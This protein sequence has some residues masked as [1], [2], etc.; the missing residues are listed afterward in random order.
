M[1]DNTRSKQHLDALQK[2]VDSQ[3]EDMQNVH[4]RLDHLSE[5]IEQFT[6]MIRTMMAH[7]N[8]NIN[9][10]LQVG[11]EG[12]LPPRGMALRGV[13]WDFPHFNGD[14]PAGWVF[15][16]TQYLEFHQTPPAQRLL[17]ASYNMEGEALVWYQDAAESRQFTSWETFVRALL[18]RFGPTAYDDPME[19]LTRLKQTS[20]VAMYKAQFEALSNRLRGLSDHH[21]LSC[22]MSGLKDEIRLPIRMLNPINLGAAFGLAKIQEEYLA[23][24]RSVFRS[25]PDR[26]FTQS[27]NYSQ[28][29]GQSSDNSFKPKY[30]TPNRRISSTSMDDKRRKGLCFH[31]EEKWNPNHVCK[32]PKMYVLQGHNEVEEAGGVDCEETEGNVLDMGEPSTPLPILTMET[33][34][35]ISLSEISGM[36]SANTMRLLGIIGQKEVEILI[37]SGST[38]SFIDSSIALKTKLRVDTIKGMSVKIANGDMV[39]SEGYCSNVRTSI[40]GNQFYPSFYVLSL[41]GCDI[42]LGVNWPVTLGPI[43]WDFSKLTME[44]TYANTRVCLKGL[45]P[46]GLSF[47]EGSKSLLQ[48]ISKG[49]RLLLQLVGTELEQKSDIIPGEIKSILD[50]FQQVFDTPKGLAPFRA[51]DHKIILKEGT[52][53]IQSDH[54]VTLFIKRQKLKKL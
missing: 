36:P 3:Q 45:S 39:H 9:R 10:E 2:Q 34:P 17:M 13:R 18:L 29:Q 14:N 35:E 8:N 26:P 42:V 38:H 43:L 28:Q 19:A 44:F 31:C 11:P 22:F 47:E 25:G 54:T 12:E 40:Q 16:A 52:P 30:T 49:K 15:K 46:S 33:K 21:K 23:F 53:P 27:G 24:T 1:A 37:D 20:S 5:R 4:G 51:H 6:D 41:G 32:A 7:Q 48:S 50:Q